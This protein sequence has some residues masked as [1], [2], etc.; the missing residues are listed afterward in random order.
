MIVYLLQDSFT[1]LHFS[2]IRS[3]RLMCHCLT[4]TGRWHNVFPALRATVWSKGHP[5]NGFQLPTVTHMQLVAL[6][7]IAAA[8]RPRHY[9]QRISLTQRGFMQGGVEARKE[10]ARTSFI[11]TPCFCQSS[12]TLSVSVQ[13]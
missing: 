10:N 7:R 9:L 5:S 2:Q 13:L 3:Q 6:F 4:G 8:T 1:V 11:F 12:L